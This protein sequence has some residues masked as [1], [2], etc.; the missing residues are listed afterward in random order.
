MTIL[1]RPPLPPHA[2]RENTRLRIAIFVDAFPV[3]SET[4][5]IRQAADLVAAGDEVTVIA[6]R[7]GERDC[8]HDAYCEAGLVHL[9]C[10]I[11]GGLDT[12]WHKARAALRFAAR[13]LF[14]PRWW[15]V[16]RIAVRAAIGGS[17]ASLLDIAA[18]MARPAPSR[19]LGDYDAVIAH[20]GP[21]G[22]RAMHLQKAG[23][24]GGALSVVFHGADMSRRDILERY[25][26]GYAEL[27][28]Y[29]RW[30]LP[31]SRLWRQRLLAWGAPAARVAVLHMGVGLD[32][33]RPADLRR[34]LQRPLRVVSVARLAEKKGLRY[35]VEAV[36]SA[37][38]AIHF[39]IIGDGPLAE[40]LRACAATLPEGKTMSLFGA[41]PQ[42]EVFDR[43]ASADVF[44][45]PSITTEEGDMEGIPVALMEAMALGALVIS[46]WHSGIPELVEDGV[47]GFLV[48]ERDPRAIARLLDE[49]AAGRAPVARMR[50]AARQT[51]E[52]EFDSRNL[53]E[54]LRELCSSAG[55]RR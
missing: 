44:L 46:T 51:I 41:C 20:F 35:A 17:R 54:R 40:E 26:A 19:H 32:R 36:A 16:L 24:L 23:L 31:V 45:L 14:A 50:A 3:H 6:G 49:I 9:V 1:E 48:D 2:C 8:P 18:V 39:D 30:L 43:L 15:P 25:R 12:P 13:A 27:V 22:V 47:S 11:R 7:R 29:A 38:A 4:F 37:Q 33:M 10:T 34:P 42:Q 28:A 55:V 21:A 52:R 5:V 53:V